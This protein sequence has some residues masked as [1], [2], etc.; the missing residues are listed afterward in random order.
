MT[1]CSHLLLSFIVL[2]SNEG[3]VAVRRELR[4]P[5]FIFLVLSIL[6]LGGWSVMFFSTT[7]RWTFVT[8]RF[9]S[10]MATAS[11][12]LTVVSLVLGVVCRYN[13]GKGLLRCRKPLDSDAIMLAKLLSYDINH[14]KQSTPSKTCLTI[15]SALTNGRMK[16]R[17]I[18]RPTRRLFLPLPL[19]SAGRASPWPRFHGLSITQQYHLNSPQWRRH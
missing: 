3:W 18:F 2:I 4:L 6:Y 9:F 16:R 17:L 12:F 10:V 11:V 7:F 5:M 1:V 14:L 19:Y 13:F 8:W 15:N